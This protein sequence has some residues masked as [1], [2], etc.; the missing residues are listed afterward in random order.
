MLLAARAHLDK[1][2]AIIIQRLL[3]SDIAQA[4]APS[5]PPRE[6]LRDIC[7]CIIVGL[8]V[9]LTDNRSQMMHISCLFFI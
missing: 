6:K 9:E 7:H 5:T 4:A 1:I 3:F 2:R 8:S